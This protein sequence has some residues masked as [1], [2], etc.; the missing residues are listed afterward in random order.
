[1]DIRNERDPKQSNYRRRLCAGLVDSNNG[2]EAGGTLVGGNIQPSRSGAHQ[3]NAYVSRWKAMR[4]LLLPVESDLPGPPVAGIVRRSEG[5][6]LPADAE[7]RIHTH[8]GVVE[9]QRR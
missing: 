9:A 5:G 4:L 1:M 7:V 3:D 6:I 8:R 2:Y